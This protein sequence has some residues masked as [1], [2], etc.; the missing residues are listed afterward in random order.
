MLS[1]AAGAVLASD[2]L[3]AGIEGAVAA[4]V[5]A[6]LEGRA[7]VP[8]AA[9]AVA[10]AVAGA[11]AATAMGDVSGVAAAAA[12]MGGVEGSAEE[13]AVC[14]GDSPAALEAATAFV[15][16]CG[17]AGAL[18]TSVSLSL[19]E[20][21]MA[22]SGPAVGESLLAKSESIRTLAA[23][24]V[25]ARPPGGTT[26]RGSPIAADRRAFPLSP[27]NAVSELE[28]PVGRSAV[29]RMLA[30]RSVV[31]RGCD[32][33]AAANAASWAARAAAA[34]NSAGVAGISNRDST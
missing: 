16:E 25:I 5:G 28:L 34:T 24:A 11:V 17:V 31:P 12:T 32:A 1:G 33:I 9:T 15:I 8:A 4:E 29:P 14:A 6:A 23:T 19:N 30:G 3:A 7:A 27:P 20:A 2:S 18:G 13:K 22:D 21:A 10:G 26:P